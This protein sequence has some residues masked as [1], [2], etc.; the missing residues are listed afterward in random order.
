Y[1]N[2]IEEQNLNVQ[3]DGVRQSNN[4]WHHNANGLIDPTLLKSVSVDAGVA[5]ADAGPG[6]VGGSLRYETR[7]VA[8]LLAPGRNFGS[9]I[10]SGYESNAETFSQTGAIYGRS[11]GFEALGYVTHAEGKNYEDGSG[12]EVEGTGVNLLSTLAKAAYTSDRGHRIEVNGQYMVDDDIRPFRANFATVRDTLTLAPNKFARSTGSIEYSNTQP[13]ERFD[14]LLRLSYNKTEID[15]PSADGNFA[16]GYF[17]A[18]VESIGGLAQ[19]TLQTPIGRLTAGV[20]FYEDQTETDNFRDPLF[21]ENATNVGAF[22]QL[23]GSPTSRLEL[24]TGLRVDYNE[25]ESVD[26]KSYDDTG[27][28]PN[29]SARYAITPDLGIRGAYA[30]VFGGLPLTAVGNFHALQYVYEDSLK[31]QQA[32]N[33]T[34]SLDYQLSGLALTAEY[35]TTT[36]K[37]SAAYNEE[38]TPAIRINGP[39]LE[40]T[41]FNLGAVHTWENAEAGV[42]YVN[43]DVKYNNADIGTNAFALGT[44]VG[45]MFK[46]HG[47]WGMPALGLKFGATSEIALSF[48]YPASS[49]NVDLDSYQ[50]FNLYSQWQPTALDSLLLRVEVNNVADD[51]YI[52]RYTSGASLG[53]VQ[54]LKDPGRNIVVSTRYTF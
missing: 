1:V 33:G 29:L 15:R 51:E 30:Y 49:S 27:V 26:D 14:P 43:T 47:A 21:E 19:N 18:L 3:V 39:A 53:F 34:V 24:S 46:L 6:A 50:V 16:R 52:N 23:R 10:G 4:I 25:F 40:T 11:N 54:P 35:F 42:S 28:S 20:D 41:G 32:S 45:E 9:F 8:D 2:G 7:D 37:N 36:I 22:A 44:P 5:G 13:T 17:N 31:S 38:D 48:D 12:T